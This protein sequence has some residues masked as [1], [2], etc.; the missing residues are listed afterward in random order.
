MHPATYDAAMKMVREIGRV[1][2]LTTLNLASS[3]LPQADQL[4]NGV[5]GR[6]CCISNLEE[7][8]GDG[9]DRVSS[10]IDCTLAEVFFFFLLFKLILLGN[11]HFIMTM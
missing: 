10:C 6:I 1:S 4:G 7:I 2:P 8:D 5:L 3:R 11:L 9:T